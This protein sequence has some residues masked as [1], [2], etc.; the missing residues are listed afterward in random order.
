MDHMV[1]G[2]VLHVA[3]WI[4]IQNAQL[5]GYFSFSENIPLSL[6]SCSLQ[7]CCLWE[8]L[9]WGKLG[10][11]LSTGWLGM[12]SYGKVLASS[13]VSFLCLQNQFSLLTSTSF[14]AYLLNL[15]IPEVCLRS[16]NVAKFYSHIQ[17]M[18]QVEISI[19]VI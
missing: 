4:L 5:T 12:T 18:W 14:K 17:W 8:A 10:T 19:F 11:T 15:I 6:S 9:I 3:K 2:N 1:E 7:C 13:S 16:V